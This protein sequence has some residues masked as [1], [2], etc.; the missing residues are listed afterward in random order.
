LNL[1][2]FQ[3]QL[4]APTNLMISFARDNQHLAI[5]WDETR[6]PD[7]N[8]VKGIKKVY[9]N[10]YKGH[11]QNGLFMKINEN[12]IPFNRFEDKHVNINPNIMNWYKVSSLYLDENNNYIEGEL[13]KPATF[14][15]RNTDFWFHKINER[16]YWILQNTGMLFDLY[17]RKY[18]G[19]VCPHCYDDIRGRAGDNSC[20]YC[21]GTGFLGGYDPAYQLLIRLKPVEQALGISNQMFV[22]EN[23][24]GAWTI[25]D[26]LL[27]N[28]DILIAPDGVF[29]QVLARHVNHA[30]GFLFH[31]ELRLRAFDPEDPIYQLK[32]TTLKPL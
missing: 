26:S 12:P 31:Q 24:P 30:G 18:S 14:K 25:S 3:K 11:S 16:N 20:P 28:R 5:T 15:M 29:Y 10:I 13:S 8:L 2:I 19:D 17:T 7:K 27:M 21:F 4:P 23:T 9:Y 32:R 1:T 6:T 22:N